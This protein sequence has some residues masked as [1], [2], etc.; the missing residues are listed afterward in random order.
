MGISSKTFAHIFFGLAT[1]FFIQNMT[2]AQSL[3]PEVIATAGDYNEAGGVSLSWTVG[4]PVVTT[5]SSNDNILTQG[6]QQPDYRI[7][8][9][10]EDIFKPYFSVKI[11]PNPSSD[12]INIEVKAV[13]DENARFVLF[14]ATGKQITE[15]NLQFNQP[16]LMDLSQYASG[17]YFGRL[18]S[19]DSKVISSHSIQKIH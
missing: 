3:S 6:F 11:Y 1:C 12:I 5:I 14:D 15:I 8:T 2:S 7:E 9:N 17:N 16:A 19:A 4:E 10:V 18:L 13:K